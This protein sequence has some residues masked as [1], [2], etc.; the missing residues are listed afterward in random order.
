MKKKDKR[1]IQV[2]QEDNGLFNSGY[3]VIVDKQTGVNYLCACNGVGFGVTP[4]LDRQG[5]PVI[6]P[7]PAEEKNQN[8]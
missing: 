7:I 4:L 8:R 6:S 5:N 1:F 3:M 2:Y